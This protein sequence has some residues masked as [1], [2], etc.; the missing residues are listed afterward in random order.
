VRPDLASLPK[1]KLRNMVE[2][3]WKDN[4]VALKN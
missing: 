2:P 3:D 4:V 1:A